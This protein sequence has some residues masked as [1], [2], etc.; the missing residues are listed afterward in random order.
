MTSIWTSKLRC[1]RSSSHFG[2]DQKKVQDDP[3][4]LHTHN[5]IVINICPKFEGH[6]YIYTKYQHPKFEPKVYVVLNYSYY[7]WWSWHRCCWGLH[8][9]ELQLLDP[10]LALAIT[11]RVDREIR[12]MTFFFN[13]DRQN[14]SHSLD[15]LQGSWK[16]LMRLWYK[17][18]PNEL[19]TI[20]QHV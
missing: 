9:R 3:I 16:N 20:T 1:R 8:S 2:Q 7:N 19:M 4:H 14:S 11:D 18:N 12:V 10:I 15:C 5:V 6:I 17:W 13:D